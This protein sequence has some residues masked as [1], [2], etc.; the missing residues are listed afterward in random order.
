[1]IVNFVW[2]DFYGQKFLDVKVENDY[3]FGVF[4]LDMENGVVDFELCRDLEVNF[5]VKEIGDIKIVRFI[6]DDSILQSFYEIIFLL[7]VGNNRY[8]ICQIF[9]E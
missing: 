3:C 6:D 5:Y 2:E 7:L 9:L 8:F 1:M 4:R